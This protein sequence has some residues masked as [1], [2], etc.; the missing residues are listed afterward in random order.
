MVKA[1]VAD[2]VAV[3]STTWMLKIYGP[4]VF[5]TPE[6]IPVVPPR[7]ISAGNAPE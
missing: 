7:R 6:I 3:A 1:F 4:A 2:R 5:G